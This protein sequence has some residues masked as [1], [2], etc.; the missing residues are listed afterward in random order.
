MLPQQLL[1]TSLSGLVREMITF[2]DEVGKLFKKNIS[3]EKKLKYFLSTPYRVGV[4]FWSL[5]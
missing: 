3:G 2:H 5:Q 1:D 4:H